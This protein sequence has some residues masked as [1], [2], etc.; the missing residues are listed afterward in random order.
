[1]VDYTQSSGKWG[2]GF[3]LMARFTDVNADNIVQAD[4][5]SITYEVFALSAPNSI[6]TATLTVSA[7]VFNTL[8]TDNEWPTVA[9]PDGYNFLWAVP[10]ALVPDQGKRY[11]FIID[12]LLADGEHLRH[13]HD[14]T[15]QSRLA[16]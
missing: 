6:A 14:H 3:A 12:I 7:V 13:I 15:T 4:V 16:A 9:Y 1:M 8:Q 11:R 5:T 2:V 10:G